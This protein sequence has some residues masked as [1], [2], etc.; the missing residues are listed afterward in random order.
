MLQ[1]ASTRGCCARAC[2]MAI[3][4]SIGL[5]ALAD[6]HHQGAAVQHRVAVA[7]LRGDLDL[8]RDPG[9]VLD[10]VLRHQARVERR[11]AGDDEDLVGVPQVLLGQPDLVED[12]LAVVG[13]PAAQGVGDRG[14]LL[15]DLLEHEVRVAALLG[16]GGVPVDVVLVTGP[17]RR[18]SR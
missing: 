9:P 18:R 3:S 12:D 17:A 5:A 2:R 6:R 7:E 14:R 15:G 13:E 10:R 4:V 8:A 1:I 11:P 16:G